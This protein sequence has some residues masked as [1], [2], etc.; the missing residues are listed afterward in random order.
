[1]NIEKFL[2]LGAELETRLSA[3][4]EKV[5]SLAVDAAAAKQLIKISREEINHA[6]SLRM[7]KTY[8][9]E[10]PDLFMSANVSEDELKAGLAEIAKIQAK[11]QPGTLL[12]PA[13]KWL[14]ELEKKFEKIHIGA[15]LMLADVRLKQLFQALSKGDHNHVATLTEMISGDGPKVDPGH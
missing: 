14:L 3:L 4:Y 6:N 9:K 5:A 2:D 11:I 1:M 12:F 10:A 15:C 13:L 8:L 7:G